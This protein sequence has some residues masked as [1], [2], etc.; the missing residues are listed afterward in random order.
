MCVL[1]SLVCAKLC[2]P[3]LRVTAV[4]R[5]ASQD[6]EETAGLETVEWWLYGH[7][8]KLRLATSFKES[9]TVRSL[10]RA[11][12]QQPGEPLELTEGSHRHNAQCGLQ[13]GNL[14]EGH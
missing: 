9:K 10:S 4:N 11:A 13:K 12:C 5:W 14:E 7:R 2:S 8:Q 6:F 1:A 3:Y